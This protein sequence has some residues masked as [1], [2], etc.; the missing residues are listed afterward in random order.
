MRSNLLWF[1]YC[2]GMFECSNKRSIDNTCWLCPDQW[3]ILIGLSV[4]R[5]QICCCQWIVVGS[6]LDPRWNILGP[7]LAN[8]LDYLRFSTNKQETLVGCRDYKCSIC[9]RSAFICLWWTKLRLPSCDTCDTNK[10]YRWCLS[11]E[12]PI[13]WFWIQT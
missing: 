8:K 7:I 9:Y 12:F 4:P 13:E 2:L 6:H 10:C 5:L 1:D 3:S 11:W